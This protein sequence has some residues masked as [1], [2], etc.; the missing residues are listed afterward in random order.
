MWRNAL[1]SFLRYRR[2]VNGTNNLK[3]TLSPLPRLYSWK[4]CLLNH[5]FLFLIKAT[6][7]MLLLHLRANEM[8][9]THTQYDDWLQ[10]QEQTCSKTHT[11]IHHIHIHQTTGSWDVWLASCLTY[12]VEETPYLCQ[13]PIPFSPLPTNTI[14]LDT[15]THT[16]SLHNNE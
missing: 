4:F 13:S 14:I 15:H 11:H 10:W 8:A 16:S 5:S 3:T 9:H 7:C 6:L 2:P 1:E 12:A